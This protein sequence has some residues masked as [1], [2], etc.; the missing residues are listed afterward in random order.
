M[1]GLKY[2]WCPVP[3]SNFCLFSFTETNT[4]SEWALPI[5][6]SK[7]PKLLE[8]REDWSL[9]NY[10]MLIGTQT[11]DAQGWFP[12]EDTE[13]YFMFLRIG[14]NIQGGDLPF[15]YVFLI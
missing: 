11:Y 12:M 14:K 3:P 6:H 10:M 7:S 2:T 15:L 9:H 4:S 13:K 8:V 5:V 1:D